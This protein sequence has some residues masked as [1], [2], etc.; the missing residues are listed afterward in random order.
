[1]TTLG[2]PGESVLHQESASA[3]SQW[4]PRAMTMAIFTHVTLLLS[5]PEQNGTSDPWWGY[6]TGLSLPI[7]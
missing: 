4:P 3:V 6:L 5:K 1:M 2:T 7:L